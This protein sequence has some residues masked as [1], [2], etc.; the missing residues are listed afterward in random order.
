VFY[1]SPIFF[2]FP[3]LIAVAATGFFFFVLPAWILSKTKKPPYAM[4]LFNMA[5]YYPLLLLLIVVAKL[6][7]S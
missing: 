3:F 1:S 5:S 4:V 2:E 7:K 6:L